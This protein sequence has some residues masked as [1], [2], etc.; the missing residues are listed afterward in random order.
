[1]ATVVDALVVTLGLD[2][3]QFTNCELQE[4]ASEPIDRLPGA[5]DGLLDALAVLFGRLPGF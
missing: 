2:P 1:M 4:V 3:A 5:V